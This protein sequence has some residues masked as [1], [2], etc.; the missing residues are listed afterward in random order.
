MPRHSDTDLKWLQAFFLWAWHSLSFHDLHIPSFRIH[1][2]IG[3]GLLRHGPE[4]GTGARHTMIQ[5]SGTCMVRG[6]CPGLPGSGSGGLGG[7]RNPL[8]TWVA[9][10]PTVT[11]SSLSGTLS[12]LSDG[13]SIISPITGWIVLSHPQNVYVEV[14]IPRTSECDCIWRK[15]HYRRWLRLNKIIRVGPHPIWLVSL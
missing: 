12:P 2:P 4:N 15:G 13:H 1:L 8:C 14:L 5:Q 6:W 11:F 10:C 7:G 3:M 9:R